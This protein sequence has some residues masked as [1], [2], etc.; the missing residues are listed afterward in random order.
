MS[1]KTYSK[2]EY[3]ALLAKVEDLKTKVVEL[4]ASADASQ[5]DAAVAAVKADMETQVASLQSQL[6]T[7][8]LEAS[9]NKA[10]HDELIAYLEEVAAAEAAALEHQ[11]RKEERIS[12]VREVASFPAAYLEENAD[13]FAD[14]SDETF[15]VALEGFK[16]QQEALASTSGS[17]N[18]I[19]SE[20]AM[21]A[22]RTTNE[23]SS[24]LSEVLALREK[25]IDPRNL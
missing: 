13:R 5:V 24:P 19:P 9:A 4:T 23:T 11:A 6:D 20:T 14:M 17:S 18:G 1:E 8:V 21:S 10:K 12:Q 22:A 25:G 2:D 16:A 15:Q 7:A 3:D